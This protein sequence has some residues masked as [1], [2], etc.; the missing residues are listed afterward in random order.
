MC[1][2]IKKALPSDSIIPNSETVEAM[3]AAQNGNL[4]AVKD[5]DALMADLN[6]DD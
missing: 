1:A 5:I 6:T 3:K 2:D 4:I